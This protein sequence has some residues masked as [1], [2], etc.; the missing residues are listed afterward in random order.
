MLEFREVQYYHL[1]VK[2]HRPTPRIRVRTSQDRKI[3]LDSC[4]I[5]VDDYLKQNRSGK[6]FYPWH[7]VQILFEAAIVLLDACWSSKD[8]PALNFQIRRVLSVTLPDCL[9][10]IS[11]IGE[12]WKEAAACADYL[13]PIVNE[14]ARNFEYQARDSIANPMSSTTITEKIRG[15]LF[16]DGP[17][18]WDRQSQNVDEDP[19]DN[20][21]VLDFAMPPNRGSFEWDVNW[22]IL[23]SE[24]LLSHHL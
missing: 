11:R 7:G 5:L 13:R 12:R 3:C 21:M 10:I 6:L 22:E 20:D 16:S 2:L 15:L 18:S 14:V 9:F 23:E 1:K 24:L 4:Q 19:Q 8:S 17:L